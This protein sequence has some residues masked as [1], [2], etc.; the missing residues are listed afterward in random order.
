MTTI[1]GP[2]LRN[3]I[4][5]L[6]Q[7]MKNNNWITPN[8]QKSLLEPLVQGFE[9]AYPDGNVPLE[10]FKDPLQRKKLMMI[11][12]CASIENSLKLD[13]NATPA[14]LELF[15]T[16]ELIKATLNPPE[17][18]KEKNLAK[19]RISAFLLEITPPMPGQNMKKFCDELAD[20]IVERQL[21][22]DQKNGALDD[23]ISDRLS[24][25]MATYFTAQ[26]K[27]A[28]KMEVSRDEI[29][30][31]AYGETSDGRSVP[32]LGVQLSNARSV[33]DA[34]VGKCHEGGYLKIENNEDK[35]G[36]FGTPS[37]IPTLTRQ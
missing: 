32:M 2:T 34:L 33:M 1:G 30:L 23:A 27:L 4:E 18:E 14:M 7:E 22:A 26:D 15:N 36:V 28:E 3:E 10:L 24:T 31:Q 5:K 12:V 6:L 11:V 35:I 29:D 17:T 8:E 20:D 19:Q 9:A 13:K 37:N 25:L 16:K 21:T